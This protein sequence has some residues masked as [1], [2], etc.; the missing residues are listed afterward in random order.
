MTQLDRIRVARGGKRPET[1]EEW[2]RYE[3]DKLA[4]RA[5]NV[6]NAREVLDRNRIRYCDYG[7]VNKLVHFVI[8]HDAEELWFYPETGLWFN[9]NYRQPEQ[10]F[11]VRNLVRHIKG[12]IK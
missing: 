1:P 11:G 9:I 10:H 7:R 2:E 6:A 3:A 8:F 5:K 12:E 4:R